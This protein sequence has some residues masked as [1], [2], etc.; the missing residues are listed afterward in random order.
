MVGRAMAIDLAK[1]YEVTSADISLERL[2]TLKHLNI[3]ILQ[4]DLADFSKIGEIVQ[5]FDFVIG[6]VPGLW[7]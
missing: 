6:A 7:F 5:P 3:N 4:A 1:K 2:E